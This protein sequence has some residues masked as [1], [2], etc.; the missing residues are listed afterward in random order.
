M[1]LS[2][3]RSVKG[4]ISARRNTRAAAAGVLGYSRP[5]TDPQVKMATTRRLAAILAA[6]VA[7]YSA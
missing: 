6:D 7:G 1:I 2:G 5:S 4:A 3:K